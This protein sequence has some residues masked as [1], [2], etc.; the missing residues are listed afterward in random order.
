MNDKRYENAKSSNYSLNLVNGKE[1][2]PLI[3][4]KSGNL[5]FILLIKL[6]A[7]YNQTPQI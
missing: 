6:M 7:H 2:E 3:Q 1:K 4:I 5:N